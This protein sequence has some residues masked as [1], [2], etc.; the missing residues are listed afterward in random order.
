MEKP[1]TKENDRTGT[2]QADCLFTEEND[3]GALLKRLSDG[4][5]VYADAV[6]KEFDITF[7]Q[8]RIM[9]FIVEQGGEVSQKELEEFLQV[10][11][12]T[13]IG[14]VGRL[15]KKGYVE[16]RIESGRH[17]KKQ[18]RITEWV[19]KKGQEM[20]KN[21]LRFEE[22]LLAGFDEHE[23]E[24]LKEYLKRMYNNVKTSDLHEKIFN[25]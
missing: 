7:S 15:E 18:I 11:R 21:R 2:P 9:M 24:K 4:L 5:K 20:D 22:I 19:K 17:G 25:T 8:A 12:Q 3:V 23:A 10:S 14:I 1:D 16:S 13:V 6:L